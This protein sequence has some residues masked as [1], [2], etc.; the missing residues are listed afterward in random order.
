MR[1]VI[2]N[3]S[4]QHIFEQIK[5]Q[6][7]AQIMSGE[8]AENEMLPSL[9]QLA[10]ELRLSVLTVTRAYNELEQEGFIASQQGRGF[11]VMPSNS[12]LFR[13]GLLCEIETNISKAIEIARVANMSDEEFLNLAKL[14]LEV[15]DDE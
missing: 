7:K 14:L 3:G 1:I 6:I 10:K 11:Y 8:L 12:E 4:P 13:E 9:R 2:S 15:K 5:E